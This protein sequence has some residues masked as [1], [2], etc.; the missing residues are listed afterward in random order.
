MATEEQT[1]QNAEKVFSNGLL[2]IGQKLTISNRIVSKLSFL[3][4]K[5]S[6]S[7]TGLIYFQILKSSDKELIASKSWGDASTLTGTLA[8]CEAT[9]DTAVTI[10]EEVIILVYYPTMSTVAVGIQ[11][12]DVKASENYIQ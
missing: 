2:R 5:Y 8:W 3:L 12:T 9:L 4:R 11:N 10:N 7:P 1:S 6:G